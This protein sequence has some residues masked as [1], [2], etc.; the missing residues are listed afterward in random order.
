MNS[1]MLS[2]KIG[3][4]IYSHTTKEKKFYKSEISVKRL[5]GTEDIIPVIIPDDLA[6]NM[7]FGDMT[8]LL[9]DIRT[10]NV[11]GTDGKTH[12]KVFFC[13]KDT[14]KYV[15]DC[16]S[17]TG[18]GY[19]CK[20]PIYRKTPLGREITDILIASNRNRFNSDYIP[21]I[22]WDGVALE[23]ADYAVGTHVEYEGRLQSRKYNKKLENGETID[24]IAYELSI[25]NIEIV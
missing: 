14:D 21:S 11:L 4:I 7:R 9:G 5:S 17:I 23:A 12:L 19:I 16:N 22:A 2:G 24:K 18:D 1:G 15:E 6:N 20:P 25:S 3:T 13:V 10:R 8:C